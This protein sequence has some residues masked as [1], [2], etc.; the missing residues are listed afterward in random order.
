MNRFNH[1]RKTAPIS[2]EEFIDGAND[3]QQ[4]KK[5]RR[6]SKA[7]VLLVGSGKI[8]NREIYGKPAILLNLKKDIQYDL[9]KYC[10]GNKQITINYLLRRGLDELINAG[11]QVIEEAE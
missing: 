10:S 2:R 5:T 4:A 3:D 1:I 7:N 8:S 9:E 6:A 11:K